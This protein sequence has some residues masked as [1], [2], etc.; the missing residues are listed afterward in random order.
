MDGARKYS[1]YLL[2]LLLG[3]ALVSPHALGQSG[4]TLKVTVKDQ[5][6]GPVEVAHVTLFSVDHVLFQ[7][8]S[9]YGTFEFTDLSPGKYGLE[10]KSLGFRT[11]TFENI[12]IT[13][14]Q[15]DSI[16]VTLIPGTSNGCPMTYEDYDFPGAPTA[17]SYHARVGTAQVTGVVRSY[18]K[19]RPA[20]LLPNAI[21]KISSKST[22]PVVIT[23][24]DKGEFNLTDALKPGKYEVTASHDGYWGAPSVP[25]W[26][27]R[28]NLTTIS[29]VL[30]GVGTNNCAA[31]I[32]VSP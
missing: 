16:P 22:L 5:S 3:C 4:V 14:N 31:M 19:E 28:E 27:A 21:I 13:N 32:V 2:V 1:P 24:D 29:L 20:Y 18:Q 26:I 8:S 30:V 15:P 9:A 7:T 10:V 6:G 17:V 12:V 25:F 11:K 23:S